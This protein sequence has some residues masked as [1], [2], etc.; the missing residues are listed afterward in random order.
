MW[1]VEQELMG[2]VMEQAVADL[3]LH[4]NAVENSLYFFLSKDNCYGSFFRIC[5]ELNLC[6]EAILTKH[7]NR[8][9]Y[10]VR[11]KKKSH[12]NTR[13]KRRPAM[14]NYI[15]MFNKPAEE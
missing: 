8:I 7:A 5:D 14:A 6:S 4:P 10:C 11:F 9:N 3:Y 2:L 12:S 15:E 1:T 13:K